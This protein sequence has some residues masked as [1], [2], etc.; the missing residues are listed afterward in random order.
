MDKHEVAAILDEIGVLLTLQGENPFKIRAYHNAARAIEALEED[1]STLIREERLTDVPGIGERIGEKVKTLVLKGKLPYYEKLKKEI[2]P[3]LLELLKLPGLGGK[4]VQI[5]YKKLKIRTTKELL[6]ACKQGKIARLAGFGKKTQESLLQEI[7]RMKNLGKRLLWWNAEEIALPILE[8]I[9][10]FPHVQRAEIAGS[11]RRGLETVGD[12]DFLIAT[13]HPA[14]VMLQCTKAPWVSKI[15]ASG[16]SKLS[17]RLK[18]GLQA[19]FRIVSESQFAFA[20][21]YFTGSKE[22]NIKMRTRARQMGG[23]LSE[24]GFEPLQKSSIRKKLLRSEEEIFH[25]LQLDYIP[26]EL[27]EATGEIE[28]AEKHHLP[29]LIEEKDLRGVFHCHTTESDGHNTL[30]EMVAA[31]NAFGWEYMG[32]A[33]HSQS[34]FQANGMN[35]QRLLAQM[36]RIRSWNRSKKSSIFLFAGLECDI[37]TQGKLDFPNSILKKLDFVIASVH[38]SFHIGEKNMTHRIIKA[39]ENP[40]V[41]MLGHVTGRLLLRRDAYAVNL[42]KI[43]DAC[44]ANDTIMELNAHPMRLDM[45]WRLWHHAKEKGLKCSINPDAHNTYDLA[46]VRAGINIARKGWLEKS[47]VFNALSLAEVQAFLRKKKG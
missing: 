26:P 38:R 2:P 3:T 37:L 9:R 21:L 45:D 39:I 41:T 16:E 14:E 34:S 30:E 23:S 17:I 44:I 8:A 25:V 4:K 35:E 36:E 33:D 18:Q 7:A 47:D 5:L 32:I 6:N 28:A 43:I 40:Y 15:L 1:L 19:D 11:L 13:N 20:W 31:A 24:Y 22:H 12:L 46:Y 29:H 27:R 10:T 42:P